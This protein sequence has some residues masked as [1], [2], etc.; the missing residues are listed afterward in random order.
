MMAQSLSSTVPKF[1]LPLNP[2]PSSGRTKPPA[3]SRSAA[4]AERSADPGLD[5]ASRK[6]RV[7]RYLMLCR[8]GPHRRFR[9]TVI[10]HRSR[11]GRLL[12]QTF[13]GSRTAG[14]PTSLAGLGDGIS[15][16]PRGQDH[17]EQSE[18]RAPRFSAS[19][20]GQINLP[21]PIRLIAEAGVA[22]C[23]RSWAY[24]RSPQAK[25]QYF[26]TTGPSQW[27]L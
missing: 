11:P 24:R 5:A 9:T 12:R 16:G 19:R 3:G 10:T 4:R 2:N 17:D 6:M 21:A 8:T 14:V 26:A 27:N 18:T 15:T 20:L 7:A 13:L 22:A 1:A 25:P 23:L